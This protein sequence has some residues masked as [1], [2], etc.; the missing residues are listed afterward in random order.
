M[1]ILAIAAT[2]IVCYAALSPI[3]RGF[4]K[5]DRANSVPRVG[6]GTVEQIVPPH[7]EENARPIG[8]QVWIRVDGRLAPA[9]AVFGS[10][11]LHVGGPAQV[12]F[13]VGHSGRIYVDRVEPVPAQVQGLPR[14]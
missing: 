10:A 11:Q 3:L 1:A 9:E 13:R 5:R 8:A 12:T 6:I 14:N 2:T 4:T 7:I